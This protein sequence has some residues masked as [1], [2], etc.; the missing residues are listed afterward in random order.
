MKPNPVQR[1]EARGPRGFWN[2]GWGGA[3]GAGAGEGGREQKH[4]AVPGYLRTPGYARRQRRLLA[5]GYK[6]TFDESGGGRLSSTRSRILDPKLQ[7][8]KR[9]EICR[10]SEGQEYTCG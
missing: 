3:L 5:I 7:K 8:K 10:P 2:W 1:L 9:A 4:G 6:S